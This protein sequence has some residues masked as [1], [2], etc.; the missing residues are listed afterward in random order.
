MRSLERKTPLDFRDC[1]RFE[2]EEE[3]EELLIMR[4]TVSTSS[5]GLGSAF[6]VEVKGRERKRSDVAIGLNGDS[7]EKRLCNMGGVLNQ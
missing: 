6:A 3:E 4:K 2:G 7:N 1:L 5:F